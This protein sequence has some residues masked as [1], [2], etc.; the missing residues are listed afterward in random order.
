MHFGAWCLFLNARPRKAK[1]RLPPA[2]TVL[3]P[4]QRV[5]KY[6]RCVL[7]L[8]LLLAQ[9]RVEPANLE[10]SRLIFTAKLL[11]HSKSRARDEH[12]V[13]GRVHDADEEDRHD[14]DS[15]SHP[16]RRPAEHHAGDE[17]RGEAAEEQ[18]DCVLPL[19]VELHWASERSEGRVR[20]N[21]QSTL[22]RGFE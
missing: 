1:S 16:H 19:L 13:I 5:V 2:L 8:L 9:F 12:E 20:I 4:G 17:Q 14:R 7:L 11:G 15:G 10:H 22:M 3:I 6:R 21:I 18:A